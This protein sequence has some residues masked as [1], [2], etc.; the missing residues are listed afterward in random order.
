LH[1]QIKV[2]KVEHTRVLNVLLLRLLAIL[3]ADQR[4]KAVMPTVLAGFAQPG[5]VTCGFKF[6]LLSGRM[7]LA[8]VKLK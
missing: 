1:L 5:V 6:S 2:S 7:Y 8:D 3:C 4:A